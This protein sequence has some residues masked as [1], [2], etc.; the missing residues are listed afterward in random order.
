MADDFYKALIFYQIYSSIIS[1]FVQCKV[2]L[3]IKTSHNR[4]M[5]LYIVIDIFSLITDFSTNE[6]G[7]SSCTL[8]NCNNRRSDTSKAS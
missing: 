7:T 2:N 8:S 1:L 4:N 3:R 6:I 5:Y